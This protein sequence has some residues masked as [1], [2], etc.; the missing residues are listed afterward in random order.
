MTEDIDKK[1]NLSQEEKEAAA[2]I[3]YEIEHHHSAYDGIQ[4]RDL[5]WTMKELAGNVARREALLREY[6]LVV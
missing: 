6:D 2:I 1:L 5:L 3:N 4:F